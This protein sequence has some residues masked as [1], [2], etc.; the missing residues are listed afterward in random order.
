MPR[1][2]EFRSA[3]TARE[4]LVAE[5]DDGRLIE[6]PGDLDAGAF[7]DFTERFG[8]EMSS[9][10]MPL[11]MIAPFMKMV[12]GSSFT[13]VREQLTV[14]EMNDVAGWLWVEYIVRASNEAAGEAAAKLLASMTSLQNGDSSRPTSPGTTE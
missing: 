13:E 11:E 9:D 7:L 5:F 14:S 6:F 3:R 4:P 2:M 1:H 8:T 12:C 10:N